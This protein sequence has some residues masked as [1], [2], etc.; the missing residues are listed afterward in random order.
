[1]GE[2]IVLEGGD[3]SG[4]STQTPLLVERLRA[5]G[6]D[7]DQDLRDGQGMAQR[8]E[9]VRALGRHDAG[10]ARGAEDIALPGVAVEHGGERPGRHAHNTFG[11]RDPRRDRL[12][13]D[14]DHARLAALTHM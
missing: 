1:M 7:V 6:R 10:D 13:A 12:G 8:D 4:K 11:D 14:V 2:F 3:A 9:L 5:V